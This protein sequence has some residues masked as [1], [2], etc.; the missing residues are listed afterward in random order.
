MNK[1]RDAQKEAINRCMQNGGE[2][3][4]I[5]KVYYNQCISMVAGKNF[6]FIQTDYTEQL[7]S[8]RGMA[9]CTTE[10]TNCFVYYSACSLSVQSP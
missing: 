1:E 3:C 8:A 5:E 2:K 10:T 7:V 9:R 4:K 6:Y